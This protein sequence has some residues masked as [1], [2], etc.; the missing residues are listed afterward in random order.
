MAGSLSQRFREIP[1]KNKAAGLTHTHTPR[2]QGA[3]LKTMTARQ[4]TMSHT[5][6]T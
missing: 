1:R 3:R 2:G 6:N 5:A 4:V